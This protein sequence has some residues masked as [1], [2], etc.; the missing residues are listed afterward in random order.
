MAALGGAVAISLAIMICA[1]NTVIYR[2][3]SGVNY[4]LLAW[5]V[6][7]RLAASPKRVAACYAALLAAL[8]VKVGLDIAVPGL[9]PSVGLPEGIALTGV[10]HV[11]GFYAAVVIW[12]LHRL[13]SPVIFRHGDAEAQRRAAA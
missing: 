7:A 8:A 9:V 10:S 13:G 6:M 12:I 1:P 5:A 11:A 4:G 2:G 3:M